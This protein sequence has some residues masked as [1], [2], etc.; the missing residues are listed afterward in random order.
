[1][2]SVCGSQSAAVSLRQSVCGSQSA[3]V[4]QE[5][6]ALLTVCREID[7]S[8]K[9]KNLFSVRGEED[10]A[11]FGGGGGVIGVRVRVRRRVGCGAG[12]VGHCWNEIKRAAGHRG[13][14]DR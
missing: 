5:N 11:E 2:R 4:T 10:G 13:P 9:K 7:T 12:G 14:P 3:A 6:G 8:E 1:M